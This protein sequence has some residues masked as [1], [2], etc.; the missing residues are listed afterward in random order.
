[1]LDLMRIQPF[2]ACWAAMAAEV[3]HSS[4]LPSVAGRLT[5]QRNN[6]PPLVIA[7]NRWRRRPRPA[8][9][10]PHSDR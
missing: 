4:V 1:M 9:P 2:M 5:G 6:A 8:D 3:C 10:A 7:V